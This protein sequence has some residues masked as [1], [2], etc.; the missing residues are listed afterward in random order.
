MKAWMAEHVFVSIGFAVAATILVMIVARDALK[1][2]NLRL[3]QLATLSQIGIAIAALTT[4]PNAGGSTLLSLSLA[5]I[6][7]ALLSYYAGMQMRAEPAA[8]T[9]AANA[10]A[11]PS[12]EKA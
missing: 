2:F 7:A 6:A 11:K 1:K 5:I 12:G 8:Q 4:G 3:F 9:G 10:P